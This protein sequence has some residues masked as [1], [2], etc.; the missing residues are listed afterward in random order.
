MNEL[1][2]VAKAPP[3]LRRGGA[4]RRG[5]VGQEIDFMEPTTPPFG[6]PSLS[7][8]GRSRPQRFIH[9]FYDRAYLVAST[10]NVRS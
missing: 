7:K 4:K 8:E 2:R 5:G 9:S 1:L 6:H 3:Q 10:K